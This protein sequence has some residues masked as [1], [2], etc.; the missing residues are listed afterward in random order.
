MSFF[1]S[2]TGLCL[3][4][5]LAL[6]GM[7]VSRSSAVQFADG[8]VAFEVPPQLSN[9]YATRNRVGDR[10]STYY[11][12]LVIPDEA[13]EPLATIEITLTEGRAN[14]L[15]YHLDDTALF[16]GTPRD[17][18]ESIPLAAVT[19][20][21]EAQAMTLVLEEPALPGQ[22]VTLALQ[23]VRNPRW[24]GVYLFEVV[25]R[26]AGEMNRPQRAGTARLQ[27]YD[28]GRDRIVN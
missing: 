14:L 13:G 24:E 25:T 6:G 15:R 8:T 20:D 7:A 17:R 18:G 10:H 26:P 23:P 16:S 11:F 22:L 3:G 19:Y 2:F 1:K 4:T 9:F 21:D 12:T 5:A 27:I 28:H